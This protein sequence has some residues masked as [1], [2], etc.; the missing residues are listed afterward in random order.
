M[1]LVLLS[2]A[3]TITTTIINPLNVLQLNE[4]Q[5]DVMQKVI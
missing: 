1:H 4:K 5:V 2:I 3:Y